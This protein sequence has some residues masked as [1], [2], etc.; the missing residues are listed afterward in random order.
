M[1]RKLT[2]DLRKFKEQIKQEKLR[3]FQRDE[4]DYKEKRVYFW[5]GS[6]SPFQPGPQRKGARTVSF[7]FTSEDEDLDSTTHG[8]NRGASGNEQPPMR[9]GV[10]KQQNR[11][12]RKKERH[13][14]GARKDPFYRTRHF[15][16]TQS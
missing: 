13:E 1:N 15:Q 11:G 3:K 14:E 6:K 9:R 12:Q 16:R 7:N 8:S 5:Q 10:N 2:E 4:K